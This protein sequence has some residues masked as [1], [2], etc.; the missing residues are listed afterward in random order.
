MEDHQTFKVHR[1]GIGKLSVTPLVEVKT[2]EDLSN[3]YTPHVAKVSE[4]IFQ[5]PRLATDYTIAGKM[6]AVI[7]DGS[8]VLGLGNIGA[9]AALPVMEGKAVIFKEFAGVDAFPLCL[10]TQDTEDI[11]KTI[12]FVAPNFAAI[13]LEDI[14]APRC[15][16]IERRLQEDLQ[17]PVM[18]DDQHGTAIV[19]L[20]ALKGALKLTKKKDIRVVIVGAGAAGLAVARLLLSQK[21]SL[22]I[23]DL[24]V[25]DSKGVICTKRTDLNIYKQEVANN[26]GQEKGSSM[27]EA[28]IGADVFIGVSKGGLLTKEMIATM[29]DNPIIFAMA[30][31]IPEIMPQEGL[32]AGAFIVA[33]GRSDFPNQINNALAY[34]GVFKGL[35]EGKLQKA[36]EEV[37]LAAAQAIYIYHEKSLSRDML[38]PSILDKNIPDVIAEAVKATKK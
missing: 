32:D 34:P 6:V 30:N 19:I 14:S 29:N 28:L 5:D 13:N 26:C 23:A 16:E 21:E 12:K 25:V 31:P 20:A 35:I 7:S 4:A 15:F 9:Q 24:K 38:L 27:E 2:K 1:K 3:V 22:S 10:A 8:A 37:K 18:H 17:I 11:I 36:T 33:T